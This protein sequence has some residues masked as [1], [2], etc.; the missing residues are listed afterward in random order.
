VE[1]LVHDQ[2]FLDAMLVEDP[3]GFFEG[4]S[5]G[6]GDEV[7]LRHDVGHLE[8]GALGEA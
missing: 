2:E 6:G 1:L 5:D 3:L 4:R 8:V 7:L